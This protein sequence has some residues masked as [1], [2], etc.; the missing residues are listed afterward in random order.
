MPACTTEEV[1]GKCS[2]SCL[3]FGRF[4]IDDNVIGIA[5]QRI[6]DAYEEFCDPKLL[7]M[8]ESST[9]VDEDVPSEEL[10]AED[11]LERDSLDYLREL[12]QTTDEKSAST[13]EARA[14]KKIELQKKRKRQEDESNA[15]A[16]KEE[17]EA[18]AEASAKKAK[19]SKDS[20]ASSSTGGASS[21]TGGGGENLSLEELRRVEKE[22][23]DAA[24]RAEAEALK[25]AEASNKAK[26]KFLEKFKLDE[27][28]KKD[29]EEKKKK[30]EEEKKKK[31]EDEAKK[32]YEQAKEQH[33]L[34]LLEELGSSSEEEVEEEDEDE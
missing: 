16:E 2:S 29:D 31:E 22:A 9:F 32:K 4:D 23:R 33:R 14:A 30:E 13:E 27:K 10:S 17:A 34:D 20:S 7:V 28:K 5:Q 15:A 26:E 12:R 24:G 3:H 6:K 21:S 1:N 8:R 19:V 18:V 25:L 11:L